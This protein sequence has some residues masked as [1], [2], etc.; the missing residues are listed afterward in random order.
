MD[1]HEYLRLEYAVV[2]IEYMYYE[3]MY[4]LS[5]FNLT[6]YYVVCYYDVFLLSALR[7]G[8]P[9]LSRSSMG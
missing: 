3:Y 1:I 4:R 2:N 7:V 8:Y 5:F 9:S 6:M